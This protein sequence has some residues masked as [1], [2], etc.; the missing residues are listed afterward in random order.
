MSASSDWLLESFL[1]ERQLQMMTGGAG[2]KIHRCDVSC[3]ALNSLA[4]GRK[5]GDKADAAAA[6]LLNLAN[7]IFDVCT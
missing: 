4:K 7:F 6:A 1:V 5:Y 2:E 3:G